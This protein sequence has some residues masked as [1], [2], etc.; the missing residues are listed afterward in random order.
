MPVYVAGWLFLPAAGEQASIGS[1]A[2]S[3]SAGI[4]LAIGLA[5]LLIL[6]L[7]AASALNGG[8]FVGWA[9]PQVFSAAGLVL[10]WRNAPAEEQ[11]TLRRLLEPIETAADSSARGKWSALRLVLAGA[12]LVG[13][14]AW[15]FSAHK[16][17][18]LLRPLG[19][20]VLVIAAIVLFLGPWWLR[21]ARD[22]VLER[23]AKVRAEERVDIAARV[24]DSVLQTLALIQRRADDPQKVIQL[25]RLQ[26]R[27]LRSWLFEGRDPNETEADLTL[28]GGV[29]QIQQDV[30]AR[31]GVPV[32]AVTVG[33]CELDDNLNALL[34]AAREA[35]VNAAKWSGASVIS[36]F[37][38][39]EPGEVSLV[40]RDRGKGF[41]PEAVPAD[42][43]GLAESVHGR[44]TRRGGTATV[45]TAP[46]EGTKVTL[47]MGRTCL[48]GRGVARD[49]RESHMS[50][51]RVVLVDDHG[52]FRSGVRAE[53]GRQVEVVGEADDV[54]P[55]I[56]LI[57]ELL[58]D[59][60]LL[61]VHLPGGGGQAVVQAIKATHPQVR[62]LALSASDAPEDVI[63]V[64]RAGAR[65]LRDED[66]LHRRAGRRGP[67]GRGR[68]RGVLAPAGRVRPGRVRRR[69]PRGRQAVGRP[70]ARPADQP[71]TGS[72]A[73]DRPG[74]HLQGD[75]PRAVHLGQDGGKP[76]VVGAAQAAALHPAP[77]DQ[78]GHRTA[79]GLTVLA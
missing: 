49:A 75:R 30:E 50:A 29:R 33:D 53:L 15:L 66:D 55:A 17:L 4:R 61:D 35:T 52:L 9:W 47:K 13:G 72:A 36:L 11:A 3:D 44:M 79:A 51:P 8:W 10:I 26:E 59:V 58:P 64:I 31:Y 42:R 71:G 32:E 48:E 56:D 7:L 24:H 6:V 69:R 65:G 1:K 34:A 77:A 38:E 67:P 76:R 43:K 22:L 63:A 54:Q 78:V 20:V 18:A 21:I 39:V 19:G 25:A 2:R 70:R 45:T 57:S 27:E 5:S 46:G 41:D 23:Q 14:V 62:F 60:V 12:L 68:R 40:V 74:L 73:A 28:T 37:A 16:S